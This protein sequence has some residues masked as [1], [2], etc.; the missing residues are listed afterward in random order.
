MR[1]PFSLSSSAILQ[2]YDHQITMT[3]LDV[4]TFASY[5]ALTADILFQIRQIQ[6]T[7]SAEDISLW[8]LGIRYLAIVII[9]YK[10]FTLSDWALFFGQ[11]LLQIVFTLYLILAVYYFRHDMRRKRERESQV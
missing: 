5:V 10:F 8:G 3:F 1:S 4:I 6:V 11:V 9:L 7:K 2:V